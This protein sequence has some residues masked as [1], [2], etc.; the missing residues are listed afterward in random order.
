VQNHAPPDTP[1]GGQLT[2]QRADHRSVTTGTC[3]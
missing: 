3:P 2:C 1:G